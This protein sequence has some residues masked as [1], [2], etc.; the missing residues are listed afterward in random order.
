[1][2]PRQRIYVALKGRTGRFYDPQTGFRIKLNEERELVYPLGDLT[3]Q[4]LNAGG[5]VLLPPTDNPPSESPG[6]ISETQPGLLDGPKA[7]PATQ[8][9]YAYMPVQELRSV[10]KRKGVKLS[11]SDNAQS[12]RAKLRAL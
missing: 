8:D 4:C 3:R 11:R 6:I 5:L 12:I 2:S 7:K 1:M 9:E 10:A